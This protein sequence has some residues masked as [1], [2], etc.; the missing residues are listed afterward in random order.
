MTW[1]FRSKVLSFVVVNIGIARR[2]VLA[3]HLLAFH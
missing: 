2:A 3:K 1:H